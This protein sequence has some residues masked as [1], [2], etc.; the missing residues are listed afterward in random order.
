MMIVNTGAYYGS[1]G[2]IIYS[3]DNSENNW[4]LIIPETK[5]DSWA[6][7]L[8]NKT[9]M[10]YN[11]EKYAINFE[12]IQPFVAQHPGAYLDQGQ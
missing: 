5:G 12:E 9:T 7:G 4:S 8:C 11:G 1:D 2:N 6:Y 3:F 10:I